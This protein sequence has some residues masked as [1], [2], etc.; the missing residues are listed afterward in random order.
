MI[1][2]VSLKYVITKATG[3]TDASVCR[4]I[5]F[6]NSHE[7]ARTQTKVGLKKLLLSS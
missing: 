1:D 4:A 6:T 2:T 5:S 7:L 3:D